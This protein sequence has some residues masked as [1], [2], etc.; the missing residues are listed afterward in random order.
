MMSGI[1]ASDTGPEMAIR[2]GL[3]A[4]GFRYRL[5]VRSLPGKPDIVFRSRRAVIFVHG[6]FWHGH[7]CHLFKWPTSRAKF[8]KS[9][10]EANRRRDRRVED[11]LGA[12]GWRVLT[13]WECSLKGR[14][15]L[16]SATVVEAAESWL[17]SSEPDMTISGM[18]D[19][20]HRPG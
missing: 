17:R 10:I 1:R 8:W 18:S 15:K 16:G 11:A 4:K 12:T 2:R 14:A 9:K 6:C 19:A 5:H 7:E 3:F 20:R 13:I